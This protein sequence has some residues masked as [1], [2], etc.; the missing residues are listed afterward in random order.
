VATLVAG[1]AS[2][3]E[4]AAQLF[5]SRKTVEH[6]VSNALMKLGVRNRTELA[7]RLSS[8]ESGRPG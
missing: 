7:A 8:A 4:I 1:G 6:H 2:N 3:P 5:I